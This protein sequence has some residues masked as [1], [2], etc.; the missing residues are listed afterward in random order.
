LTVNGEHRFITG[1]PG[2]F[3]N[4]LVVIPKRHC[5]AIHLDAQSL[6]E[7]LLGA[8]HFVLHPLLVLLT[9]QFR[10][11]SLPSGSGQH[12]RM[13]FPQVLMRCGMRLDVHSIVAHVCKLFPRDCFTAA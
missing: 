11:G 7:Q 1:V 6:L 13:P 4:V 10:P 3:L 8:D 2:N 5:K 9:G 12:D